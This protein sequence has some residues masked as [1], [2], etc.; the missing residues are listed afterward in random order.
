MKII[1]Q[2]NK[3]FT[4][5]ELLVTL[6]IISFVSMLTVPVLVQSVGNAKVGPT[7]MRAKNIFEN[8]VGE[9]LADKG[10]PA[11]ENVGNALFELQEY[12]HAS[13]NDETYD[14]KQRTGNNLIE[15]GYIRM[16]TDD[17]ITYWIAI[18]SNSAEPLDMF[19]NTPNNQV[20]GD[21]IVDINGEKAPNRNSKDL[22]K[23]ILYNDGTLRPF[24]AEYSERRKGKNSY[25]WK[26][27]QCDKAK[28]NYA[29]TCAGSIFENNLKVIYRR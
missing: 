9:M 17:E 25:S 20:Y 5:A 6:G 15:G 21:V 14:L 13:L 16:D 7:L 4:L 29:D 23:F 2:Q 18:A 12:I 10:V 19:P 3:G 11:L 24:G 27:N 26:N 1:K 8:G 28:V 22:F